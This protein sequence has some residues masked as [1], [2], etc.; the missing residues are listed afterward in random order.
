[1]TTK[2]QNLKDPKYI[3]IIIYLGVMLVGVLTGSGAEALIRLSEKT[4]NLLSSIKVSDNAIVEEVDGGQIP[5]EI[6]NA[7]KEEREEAGRGIA[8]DM[9]T[10]WTVVKSLTGQCI[11]LNNPWGSQCVNTT[12]LL[13]E[14]MVGYYMSTCGTNSARGIWDCREW[15]A[16]GGYELIYN[17]EDIRPGDL[18][19]TNGGEF[20]HTGMAV[21]YYKNGY[22]AVFS[23]NQGGEPCEKGGSSANTI[24]LNMSTFRGAFRWHGWDSLFPDPTPEPIPITGCLEWGVKRGDTMSKIMLDCEGT[25]KYGEAMNNY[26]RSWYSRIYKP[27]Q[28]VYDGWHSKSG[29]GLFAGDIIDH[30]IKDN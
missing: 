25:V 16:R 6:E 20:G 3:K 24:M 9:S 8:V 1:M 2:K 7:S 13:S 27:G 26:A 18:I 4:I 21:D 5:A 22:L 23:T 28:S 10:P 15:N 11:Y 29:V 17:V 14:N 30:K 19:V 12:N